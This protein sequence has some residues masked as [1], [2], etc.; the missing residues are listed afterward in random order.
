[1][2]QVCTC[3]HAKCLSRIFAKQDELKRVERYFQLECSC[4]GDTTMA[5]NYD[6]FVHATNVAA[7]VLYCANKSR[8]YGRDDWSIS[9]LH[10]KVLW[11]TLQVVCSSAYSITNIYNENYSGDQTMTANDLADDGRSIGR[12]ASHPLSVELAHYQRMVEMAQDVIHWDNYI[13]LLGS[14]MDDS[15]DDDEEEADE[16]EAEAEAE[17]EDERG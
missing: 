12:I 4:K 13:K 2:G 8:P 15:D 10:W 14:D 9:P 7:A 16:A 1:M 6:R 17:A 5:D 11:V 3:L